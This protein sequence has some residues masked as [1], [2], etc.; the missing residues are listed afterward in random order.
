M[1]LY[2]L[3]D[4]PEYADAADALALAYLAQKLK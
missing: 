3:Q 4:F 1:K 2:G